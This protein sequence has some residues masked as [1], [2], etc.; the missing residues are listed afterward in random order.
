MRGRRRCG[1]PAF[2]LGGPRARLVTVVAKTWRATTVMLLALVRRD[3]ESAARNK[4]APLCHAD[5]APVVMAQPDIFRVQLKLM[6][7]L[8]VL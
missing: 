4:A 7:A 8:I 6:R 5:V 1:P 3:A 2:A